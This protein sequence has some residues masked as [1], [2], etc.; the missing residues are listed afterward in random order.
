M[1]SLLSSSM[2]VNQLIEKRQIKINRFGSRVMLP[3]VGHDNCQIS[4][5][6]SLNVIEGILENPMEGNFQPVY[7]KEMLPIFGI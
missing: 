6:T 5:T 4:L 7:I 2:F 1:V 3:C